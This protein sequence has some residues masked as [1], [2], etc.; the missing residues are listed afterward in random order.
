[1]LL[2]YYTDGDDTDAGTRLA[3]W[4]DNI[5]LLLSSRIIIIIDE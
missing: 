1:M 5:I 2:Y 3:E 4:Y